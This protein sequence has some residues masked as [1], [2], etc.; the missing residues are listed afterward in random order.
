M[1]STNGHF[2]IVEFLVE[3]GADIN[4]AENNG[5]TPLALSTQMGH[6]DVAELLQQHGAE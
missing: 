5:V 2:P 1:S 4:Q 6:E 3:N